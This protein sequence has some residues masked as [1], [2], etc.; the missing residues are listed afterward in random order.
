MINMELKGSDYYFR[1]T[2]WL[3]LPRLLLLEYDMWLNCIN[4]TYLYNMEF[5]DHSSSCFEDGVVQQEY[6]SNNQ[7][8]IYNILFWKW[9]FWIDNHIALH[10]LIVAVKFVKLEVIGVI[11]EFV[12]FVVWFILGWKW[13]NCRI[14][15]ANI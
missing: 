2:T 3:Q 14:I 11:F 5:F 4:S 7:V 10:D 6:Y 8:Q 13:K 15:L 12:V 9:C 1:V